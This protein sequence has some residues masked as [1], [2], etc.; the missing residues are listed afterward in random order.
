M[1]RRFASPIGATV[2]LSPVTDVLGIFVKAP[3]S[4]KVKTRLAVA[5]GADGAADLYRRMAHGI[6]SRSV[7]PDRYR[8]A[9]WFSPAT[10]E[11]IVQDWLGDLPIDD[12]VPQPDVG[13]G[14]RLLAAFERHR[15]G[16]ATR[17]I[18]IGSDS[19]ELNV[20]LVAEAFE[21]LDRDDVV[22]GPARDGGFYLLGLRVLVPT[23]FQDVEWSTPGVFRQ[24]MTNATSLHLRISVLRELRDVDTVADALSF[25]LLTP[26][27]VFDQESPGAGQA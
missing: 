19:P 18:V 17:V 22:L 5:I 16:G 12:F 10:G 15:A 4:G 21:A 9:V 7:A 25:G 1:S 20:A 11:A 3:E 24:V 13:L 27:E 6:I 26:L 2:P 14:T 8:S 23:L